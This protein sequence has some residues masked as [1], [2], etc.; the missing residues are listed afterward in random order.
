MPPR[1]SNCFNREK[2]R[3]SLEV[4]SVKGSGMEGLALKVGDSFKMVI[5]VKY[6]NGSMH[7]RRLKTVNTP[8][9]RGNNK[10]PQLW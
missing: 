2:I 6:V 8:L 7:L 9:T 5:V 1:M 10:Q 3:S 4:T